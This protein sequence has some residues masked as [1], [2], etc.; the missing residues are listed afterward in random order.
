MI[1]INNVE[2]S[3]VSDVELEND[4]INREADYLEEHVV[5]VNN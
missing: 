3:D 1:D 2:F 4:M 5:E